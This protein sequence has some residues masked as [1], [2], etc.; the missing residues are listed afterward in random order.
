[1]SGHELF[2]ASAAEEPAHIVKVGI[3][4]YEYT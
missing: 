1:M 3:K 4:V 2:V